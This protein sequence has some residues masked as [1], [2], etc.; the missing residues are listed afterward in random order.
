MGGYRI[1]ARR[2]DTLAIEQLGCGV[3]QALPGW[4][5]PGHVVSPKPLC[6]PIYLFMRSV[7]PS[8][9][10]IALHRRRSTRRFAAGHPTTVYAFM[11]AMGPINDH[12]EGCT[13]RNE[14]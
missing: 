6:R 12:A 13:I 2:P 7:N 10:L 4:R 5:L 8:D 3:Q 14:V 1:D 11:Q 9:A